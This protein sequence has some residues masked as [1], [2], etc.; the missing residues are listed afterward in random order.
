VFT[1]IATWDMIRPSRWLGTGIGSFKWAYPAYRRPEIILLE[2]RSNTETD[3]AEDEYL[4]IWHDEGL[5]G[6]GIFLWM[7]LTVSALGLTSLRRLTLNGPSATSPPYDERVYL[8]LGYLGAWW[9]AL[10]HWFMDVSVRFVS[11]G[12][13]SFLL[14]ALVVSLVRTNPLPETQEEPTPLDPRLRLGIGVFWTIIF[15]TIGLR[16]WTA[17]LLGGLLIVLGELLESA[18]PHPLRTAFSRATVPAPLPVGTRISPLQWGALVLGGAVLVLFGRE[19]VH[20]FRADVFHNRAIFFSRQNIWKKSPEFDARVQS[21]GFPTDMRE[22]YERIGGALE[23]YERVV[24]LNPNFPMARYFIGNVH[25]DWGSLLW[26]Q[27]KSA[28]A[29][30]DLPTAEALHREAEEKWNR[31]LST[32][33]DVKKFAPNYVQTHHQVGLAYLKLGD[34]AL[35]F[36]E[37]EKSRAAWDQALTNFEL[38]RRLDPVFPANYYRVAYIHFM[39]GDLHRA[40]KT[41]LD[42]LVYNSTNVVGRVYGDRNSETYN[43]LGRM[44]YAALTNR[45]PSGVLPSGDADFRK[46][47]TYF[48]EALREAA[49]MGVEQEARLGFEPMKN[50]AILYSRAGM[51]DQAGALWY[52]LRSINPEDPDVKRVFTAPGSK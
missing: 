36:G 28:R 27:S 38:Y 42:A 49:R 37:A 5:V 41:Y 1:W 23:H 6:L 39:R 50:L 3:H 2:G 21:A 10:M 45:R 46:A 20:L 4:E 30:G 32:Y 48:K 12:I 19:A 14:P 13:Y 8:L 51:N 52:R 31:A 47:E 9:G 11:S 7:V 26:E 35:A 15:I 18:H 16:P 24:A 22:S 25:N 40:E 33:E 43:N 17:L 29:R 44:F 34:M